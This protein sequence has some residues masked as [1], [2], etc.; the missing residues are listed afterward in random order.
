MPSKAEL[1]ALLAPLRQELQEYKALVLAARPLLLAA[2]RV[3][4]ADRSDWPAEEK[5]Y[6]WHCSICGRSATDEEVEAAL[7]MTGETVEQT[8]RAP[9]S[10]RLLA[11]AVERFSD[12][13]LGDFVHRWDCGIW[14]G[15]D[16]TCGY[17][18]WLAQARVTLAQCEAEERDGENGR[19]SEQGLLVLRERIAELER[20]LNWLR[21]LHC[22][23]SDDLAN[24]QTRVAELERQ[25]AEER[26][27]RQKASER[28]AQAWAYNARLRRAL[29]YV[30]SGI[31][32][33]HARSEDE[34]CPFCGVA[35]DVPDSVHDSA[36]PR[37]VIGRALRRFINSDGAD[38][39]GAT[40]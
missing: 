26:E 15:H 23:L 31:M 27:V 17:A 10:V 16:C 8:Q 11:D 20:Q 39:E 36:C 40:K 6:W 4:E 32:A 24:E 1:E 33:L 9:Q 19:E 22:T 37:Y 35:W 2:Q 25:L 21:S 18:E 3:A 29:D 28:L 30:R 5:M 38:K 12:P 34:A 14:S 7:N 13:G